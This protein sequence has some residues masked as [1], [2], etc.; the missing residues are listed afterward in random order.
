ME[1][2]LIKIRHETTKPSDSAVTEMK[3]NSHQRCV[4]YKQ[5]EFKI[6]LF[7]LHDVNHNMN[8]I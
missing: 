7:A 2:M 6:G 3:E 8:R 4:Y 5:W 1:H